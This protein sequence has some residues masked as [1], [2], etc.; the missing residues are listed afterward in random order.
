MTTA[1]QAVAAASLNK[2][3]LNSI[4]ALQRNVDTAWWGKGVRVSPAQ[5]AALQ[6]A[7]NAVKVSGLPIDP[8]MADAAKQLGLE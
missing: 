8:K 6:T 4:S 1:I 7:Y 3:Q 2:R 5:F